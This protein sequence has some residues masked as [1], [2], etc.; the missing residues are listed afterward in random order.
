VKL[1]QGY[2]SLRSCR[3]DQR[4]SCCAGHRALP[5]GRD[6]DGHAVVG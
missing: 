6:G 4:Q 2:D 3:E 5:P 1:R